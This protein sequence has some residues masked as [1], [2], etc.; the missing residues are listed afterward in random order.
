[1][2]SNS[3]D[4][5]SQQVARNSNKAVHWIL[6]VPQH[7]FTPYLPPQCNYIIGQLEEGNLDSQGTGGFLH[8]QFVV[9]FKTQTRLSGV[10]K[11]FGPYHAEPTKTAAAETYCQK[12]DTRVA[13]TQ[14]SLGSRPIK[15][16]SATDWAIVLG[17]VKSGRHDLI[18][19]DIYLRY[20]SNIERIAVKN[21]T[22]VGIE[23]TCEVYYGS[24]GTG[25]SRLAWQEA[26]L[27]AY[28]KDP[29][30]KFW[31]GYSGQEHVVID[32]FR[33]SIA[34][35]HLLRWL[36]RYPVLVEVKGS[37]VVFKAKKIWITSNLHPSLWYPDL[38]PP[39]LAALLRRLNLRECNTP[40]EFN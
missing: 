16:G 17:H 18:P 40:I 32:E 26:G 39:T 14:F 28:P 21:A 24:T 38:D 6:T 19:P 8:W 11:V 12:E 36:D 5:S 31:D 13:G 15:R 1:M 34:I 3:N 33:G 22:P 37:S 23:R 9:G 25:K 29:M 30:S 7:C 4:N 20:F 10:R 2:P 35:S 27:D